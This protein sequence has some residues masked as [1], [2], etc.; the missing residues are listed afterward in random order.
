MPKPRQRQPR[1]ISDRGSSEGHA[2]DQ[3]A[4]APRRRS[5]AELALVYDGVADVIYLLAVEPG[6]VY[7]FA[8]VNRAFTAATGVTS[9]AVVGRRVEEILPESSHALVLGHYRQAIA[10]RSRVDWEEVAVY[11]AGTKVGEVTV[12]P[13][14]DAAGRCT[15]LLGTVHD[16]SEQRRLETELRQA[17]KMEAIGQLAGGIAHDFNNLLTAIGG[18]A[19]L[20]RDELAGS[21]ELVRLADEVVTAADQAARL[22]R[23]ILAF[24]RR[25]VLQPVPLDLSE[26]VAGSEPILRRLIGED[27]EFTV[28]RT[29]ALGAIEADPNQLEQ[30]LL[31][32]AVNARDAMPHGG[33]LV[34]ETCDV[35]LDAEYA[36]SHPDVVAGPHSQLTVSDTGEG[37]DAA[38]QARIFEPFFTTKG[39]GEGTGLGLSMVYGVVRQMGGHIWVYSEPGQGTTF[40]LYFPRTGLQPQAIA[41]PSAVASVAPTRRAT[42]LVVEDEELVRRFARV[43]LERVGHTVIEAANGHDA[44]EQAA[45]VDRIDLL[46]SDVVMPGM[47]AGVLITRLRDQQPGLPAIFMSG[48]SEE[49]LARRGAIAPGIQILEKPLGSA[50]LL[51]A[52]DRALASLEP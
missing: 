21:D 27:I 34:I 43:V 36:A 17:Q 32:L 15:H 38:T 4:D 14:F 22:V 35:E 2:T 20:L 42:I 8:S 26:I 51:Q 49:L 25:Q 39:Q 10:E 31:N 40:R 7:R 50:A 23:Q 28:L 16:V 11:P 41:P 18:N 44:L 13:I 47:S 30:V 33:R 37:M 48:Y 52:V 1:S 46:V 24:S 19:Q 3:A 6:D 9:E 45:R 5:E 12:A 29:P